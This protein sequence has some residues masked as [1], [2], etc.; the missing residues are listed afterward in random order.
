MHASIHISI[1]SSICPFIHCSFF[2]PSFHSSSHLL[3]HLSIHQSNHHFVHPLITYASIHSHI[4]LFILS[5]VFHSLI[6]HSPPICLYIPPSTHLFIH[7]SIHLVTHSQPSIHQ[8]IH[9]HTH[10]FSILPSVCLFIIHSSIHLS[11]HLATHSHFHSSISLSIHLLTMHPSISIFI[12]RKRG[13]RRRR[14]EREGEAWTEKRREREGNATHSAHAGV[15]DVH[16]HRISH[17]L[18]VTTGSNEGIIGHQAEGR[19][20]VCSDLQGQHHQV[21]AHISLL[22]AHLHQLSLAHDLGKRESCQGRGED[23]GGGRKEKGGHKPCRC[24]I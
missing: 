22:P 11:I 15:L 6:I 3:F 12:D 20:K 16:P 18:S 7:L 19:D 2:C 9:P 8:S 23:L 4:H 13:K 17:H 24:S 5:M 10:P 21:L 1:H 14:E